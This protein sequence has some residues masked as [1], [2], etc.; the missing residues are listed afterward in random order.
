MN[1]FENHLTLIKYLTKK[2]FLNSQ[3]VSKTKKVYISLKQTTYNTKNN[4]VGK[5]L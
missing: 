1:F 2:N 3:L 5:S 4:L